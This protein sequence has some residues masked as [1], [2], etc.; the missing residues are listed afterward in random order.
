MRQWDQAVRES[1]IE[2]LRQG[3]ERA[4]EGGTETKFKCHRKEVGHG[5]ERE[6]HGGTS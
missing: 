5:K 4:K 2:T 6:S 1:S 3:K